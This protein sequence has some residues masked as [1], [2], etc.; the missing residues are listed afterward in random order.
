MNKIQSIDQLYRFFSECNGIDTDTRTLRKGSLFFGLQGERFN[1]S[2]YAIQALRQGCRYAVVEPSFEAPQELESDIA[3]RVW[4]A[5]DGALSMLQALATEHRERLGIPIIAITG[6][7]GKTTTKELVTQILSSG[8]RVRSTQGN[9]NNSIGVPLTL[10]SFCQE[11]EIGI[12]EM[13]ASHIGDIQELVNIVHPNYGIITNIGKAHLAGFGSIEGV[14]Q[15]KGELYHYIRQKKGGLF[16]CS[17]DERLLQ[18]SEGIDRVMYGENPKDSISGKRIPNRQSSMLEISWSEYAHP[19]II[20][21]VKSRLVG[22]YNLSNL[23][24]AIAVGRFFSISPEKIN[25]ALEAYTPKNQR[26]QLIS[27]SLHGN[28]LIVDAYNANPSSMQVAVAN[29]IEQETIHPLKVLI[30]GDMN[31]L[32]EASYNEHKVLIEQI[33]A[34]A[35]ERGIRVLL[36]GANFSALREKFSHL[37]YISYFEDTESLRAYVAQNPILDALILL[38]G[39]RSMKIETMVDL[40]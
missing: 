10:L 11:D 16:V 25:R 17:S 2:D 7:N 32:G 30:L 15:A 29:L 6:T 35:P 3:E 27:P 38:K 34:L 36:A 31:E 13:G 40:C 18:M 14:A 24:C 8:F 37:T 26:S 23:L 39:S 21:E 22:G 33:S 19:E 1:G 28:T 20:Y 12:V 4:V 5:P 9:L